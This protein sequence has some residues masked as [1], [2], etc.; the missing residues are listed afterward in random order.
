MFSKALGRSIL[1]TRLF[2]KPA[3]WQGRCVCVYVPTHA[4]IG[5]EGQGLLLGGSPAEDT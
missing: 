2:L 4:R 5:A 3:C 1:P